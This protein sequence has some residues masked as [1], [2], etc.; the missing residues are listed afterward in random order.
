MKRIL[1]LVAT[2][3]AAFISF[4]VSA[5]AQELK[6]SFLMEDFLYGYRFNPALQQST[7]DSFVGL[8]F[9]N[10]TLSAN[11][12]VGLSSYLFPYEGELLTGLNAK[13]PAETFLS[14]LPSEINATGGLN[15]NIFSAGKRL[16]DGKSFLT[17]EFN[18]R[19]TMAMSMPKTL[20]EYLKSGDDDD[21]YSFKDA[22]FKTK[23]YFEVSA[24]YSRKFDKLTLGA[25]VKGLFGFAEADATINEMTIVSQGGT[26]T[27]TGKGDL[28]IA[29]P[30]VTLITKNG[31]YNYKI[32]RNAI[33]FSGYGLALDFGATYQLTDDILLSA[34]VIDLGAIEWI[35]SQYGIMDGVRES[36]GTDVIKD[37]KEVCQYNAA[38]LVNE[39]SLRG[40]DGSIN[41][42]ARMKLHCLEGLSTA[43]TACYRFGDTRIADFRIGSAYNFKSIASVAL[44]AGLTSFGPVLGTMFNVNLKDV[45]FY[46]GM[47]GLIFEVTPQMLPIRKVNTS[48]KF[49]FAFRH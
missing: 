29:A 3:S 31:H 48:F 46:A 36:S 9:D 38:P 19:S 43:A 8:F 41:L 14:G 37:M 5:N 25:T 42:G 16:K 13:I 10:L 33:K 22:F 4:G 24:G 20:F 26:V 7:T 40:I 35:N 28:N 32:N 17:F 23:N 2:I 34:A 27:I 21:V 47:D 6:T 49:G 30:T 11:T 12:N 44:S 45:S 1:S 15:Y 18:E 39:T